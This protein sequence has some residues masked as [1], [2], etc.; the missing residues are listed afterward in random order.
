MYSSFICNCTF[1]KKN[2][3]IVMDPPYDV[4]LITNIAY[5]YFLAIWISWIVLWDSWHKYATGFIIL[6]LTPYQSHQVIEWFMWFQIFYLYKSHV[7]S[8]YALDF[9]TFYNYYSEIL[10]R[11]YKRLCNLISIK[12]WLLPKSINIET[13]L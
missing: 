8:Y 4:K 13:S 7:A 3:S 12:L 11:V 6:T 9:F 10:N 5:I 2:S 1:S